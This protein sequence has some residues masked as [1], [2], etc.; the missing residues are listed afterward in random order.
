M[1]MAGKQVDTLVTPITDPG[2]ILASFPKV[3]I[4]GSI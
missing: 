2:R 1:S 3:K 4:G